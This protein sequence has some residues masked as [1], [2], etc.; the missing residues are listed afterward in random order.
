MTRRVSVLHVKSGMPTVD[1]ARARLRAELERAGKSGI[2]VLKII[3]GY[4]SSGVGGSLRHA[5]RRSLRKRLKEGRIRCFVPGEAWDIFEEST[6]EILDACPELGRD[7]DLKKHN[8]GVT[9]VLL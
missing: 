7:A 8:E 5:I 1:E 2:V 6:R 9:V 4:G 3:H